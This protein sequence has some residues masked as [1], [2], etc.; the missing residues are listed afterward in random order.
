MTGS[1]PATGPTPTSSCRPYVIGDHARALRRRIVVAFAIAL[2]V[3]LVVPGLLRV[4]LESLAEA[5]PAVGL[6]VDAIDLAGFAAVYLL[7]LWLAVGPRRLA[8]M[9]ILVWGSR[10]AT[11]GYIAVTGIRDPTD[12]AAAAEWIRTHPAA[13]DE[14]P[15]TRYWRA[16]AH[17]VAGDVQGARSGLSRITG[18]AGYE[19]AVAS[20]SAQIALAEGVEP[21]LNAVAAAAQGWPDPLGRAVAMA[22]LGAL[23]A[24][25]AFACG[26]DD[27]AAALSVR[28]GIGRRASRFFLVRAWLPIIVLTIGVVLLG[29]LIGS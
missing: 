29:R 14:D 17:L 22:N 3:A 28:P 13:K 7:T 1:G 21:D 25:R 6:I 8:A 11:A 9:E 10:Y 26:E 20:L 24:Q 12:A 19:F 23:R 2:G 27:V 16:H 4:V 18:I 15:E 5:T